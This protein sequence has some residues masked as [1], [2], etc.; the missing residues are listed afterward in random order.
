MS[1]VTLLLGQRNRT[2][3]YVQNADAFEVIG[4]TTQYEDL[5][6]NQARL[7]MTNS[8]VLATVPV[9]YPIQ[10][11]NSFATGST[12]NGKSTM[13]CNVFDPTTRNWKK[14]T[15]DLEISIKATNTARTFSIDTNAFHAPDSN[16]MDGDL[17]GCRPLVG[18]FT[19][20]VENCSNSKFRDITLRGCV[21]CAARVVGR[22]ANAFDILSR[23]HGDTVIRA[24]M[25]VC[26]GV[27]HS[28]FSWVAPTVNKTL[29]MESE[30]SGPQSLW[31]P[32]KN[33]SLRWAPMG[34]TT[35]GT[36]LDRR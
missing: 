11:W 31:A 34:S 33:R 18:A 17:L 3:V 28:D 21:I 4:L 6:T 19:F 25:L 26:A 12:K 2:A 9:G 1:G 10:D 23:L 7:K 27:L 8:S 20:H 15:G 13:S 30:S 35:Q 29:S 36:K 32:L 22:L 5:P 24:L 14:G 16:I